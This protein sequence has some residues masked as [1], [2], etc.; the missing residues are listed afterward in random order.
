MDYLMDDCKQKPGVMARGETAKISPRLG[1]RPAFQ[2]FAA[3]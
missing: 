2:R 3:T 1:D